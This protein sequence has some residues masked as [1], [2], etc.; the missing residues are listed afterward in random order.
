MSC[1]SLET[2][3]LLPDGGGSLLLAGGFKQLVV[4]NFLKTNTARNVSAYTFYNYFYDMSLQI[5]N[6][7]K[8][9]CRIPLNS[10]KPVRVMSFY[11]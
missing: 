10:I 5:P 3:I 8:F 2:L 11:N 4:L 1:L 9:Q 7:F 6:V